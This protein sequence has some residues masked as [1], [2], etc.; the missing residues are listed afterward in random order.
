MIAKRI[1]SPET[2]APADLS[3]HKGNCVKVAAMGA[4]TSIARAA[5]LSTRLFISNHLTNAEYGA[6]LINGI[7]DSGIIVDYREATCV[8]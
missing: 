7:L 8:G 3:I 6:H 4:P 1:T 2:V 5:A